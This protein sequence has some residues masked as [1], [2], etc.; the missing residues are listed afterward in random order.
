MDSNNPVTMTFSQQK[1]IFNKQIGDLRLSLR[2]SETQG[3]SLETISDEKLGKFIDQTVVGIYHSTVDGK[4]VMANA[5]LARIFGFDSPEEMMES[6]MDIGNQLYVQSQERNEW[7]QSFQNQDLVGPVLWQG[8]RT[9]HELLWLEDYACV[10]RDSHGGVLG[11]EGIV[12]DVTARYLHTALHQSVEKDVKIV[13]EAARVDRG[14]DNE[15]LRQELADAQETIATLRKQLDRFHI[16]VM[17]SQEGLWVGHPLPGQPWDSPETPAWYSSQFK[18]LLGFEE[19]EFPP[20]LASWADRLHPEDHARVFQALRDHIEHQVPYEVESRLRTK[21][22]EY[23][24]FRAKGQGIFDE[25]GVFVRGGGTIRDITEEKEA[26][27]VLKRKHA[28]L[29]AVVE[30]TSDIIFMKDQYGRYLLVNSTGAAVLGC[31]IEEIVGKTDGELFLNGTHPLFTQYDQNVIDEKTHQSFEIDIEDSGVISRTFLVTKEVFGQIDDETQGLYCIAR[32]ITFRKAAELTIQERE[33]RYRAIMENAYDLITE[34]DGSGTFLYASPNFEEVLGYAPHALLGTNIF[35]FV[36]S[37]DQAIVVKEFTEAMRAL[38]SGR[39]IYRYRH[40]NGEYRW[41]EST[42]RVFQTALGDVR[43]VIV[44][45]DITDRKKAEEALEAI[46]KGSVAAGNQ[47]FFQNLVRQLAYA[48]QVPL[49]FLAERVEETFPIVY[50]LTFWN[51]DHFESGFEYDC[52]E[53]PCEKVF[54][55]HPVYFSQGVQELFPNN[56]TVKALELEGY[57]GTPLFNSQG[58]VVGNLAIMGTQSLNLKPQDHA[59]L[60]IF[61]ARAGAELERKR[62]IEALEASQER[63]RAIY[64][65]SPLTYF[66]VD[67]HLNILSVNQFGAAILGYA[68]QELVGQSILLVLDPEDHSAF[69]GEVEKSFA[70]V[71]QISQKELRKVKKDGTSMWVKET[72]RTIIGP[73]QQQMLLLSCEDI[74]D[75]KRAEDALEHSERQVR[76]T[77]KMEAIGTLAGGIAHDFNNILGAILGYS[78][79]AMAQANKEPKLVAYLEEVLTAGHRAKELVK[80]ILAFSRRSDHEREAVD[81]NITVQEALRMVRATL[82]TTIEIQ[83]TV[84]T[85]SAVVF[86]DSTQIHQ[87]IMNLCA[88]AEQAMRVQGGILSLMVTS[89]EVRENSSQEFPEL[90]PGTYLQLKIQDSGQGMASEILERIFEPFFTTKALGEGTGLGLAVVHGIIVGHGGHIHAAS[91]VGQGTTFTILLPRLDV[92]LP[93]QSANV[94]DWPQGKGRVLFV[95]DEDVLARWGEQVLTYLG[96]TV[97]AKTNPHEA[98]QLLRRQP[99]RFDVVVTDQTMPTMSGETLAKALLEIR[100]DIPIVL[101]TG[102]SHTMSEEKARQLGLKRFLM[103]PVNGA[104]LAKTLKAV[105]EDLAG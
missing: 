35:S 8:N 13:E 104:V 28:L 69:L 85:D 15:E 100:P 92:V 79:L 98:V 41:F 60:Q 66:T 32:D 62:A 22:G 50:G 68:A 102:F 52:G 43:G 56:P 67:A 94:M 78:E 29:T 26:E 36:H 25:Q 16:A 105:F 34:V 95:D 89:T 64:D 51:R 3:I 55:G 87:V 10:I 23:R 19:D 48:I 72:C 17:G 40:H 91:A 27:D 38:G 82:P 5:P 1:E 42:G 45:R 101:C 71:N 4:L 24:W 81:L 103:K 97:V 30:G 93:A 80:Q 47:D 86:A 83:S 9:D 46:V 39:A 6:V 49:V 61:A 70:S 84:A 88:N 14:A 75:R 57:C 31:R 74:T 11:Y 77:Q 7:K 2:S 65:Q 90:K 58:D 54:D 20:V 76:Q 33:K 73:D 37:D 59:L 12:L 21:Q 99:D 44:S 96:Y 63:Y 18:A 53:G